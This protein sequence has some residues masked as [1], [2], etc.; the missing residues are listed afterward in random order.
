MGILDKIISSLFG[1]KK[2]NQ[3]VNNYSQPIN[4]TEHNRRVESYEEYMIYKKSSNYPDDFVIFDFE[5]T[6]L[7]AKEEKIIQIGALKYRNNERIDEFIT[8]VNPQRSIPSFITNL[9]GIRNNDVKNSPTIAQALPTFLEFIGSD[10]II[11]HNADFDMKFLLNN[12]FILNIKKIENKVIDTLSLSRKYIKDVNGNKLGNY[13]LQTLKDRL[14]IIVGSHN[15]EDDCMVCAE[16]YKKCK[17]IQVKVQV[18]S[19][20]KKENIVVDNKTSQIELQ[21]FE[22]VKQI[23]LKNNKVIKFLKPN[24]IGNYYD[25]L[26]FY[27]LVR[28]K[29]Q[30]KKQYILTRHSQDE[31]QSVWKEAICEA[32]TKGETG[33][34]RILFNS[35][36]D[37]FKIESLIIKDFDNLMKSLEYYRQ[38]VGSGESHIQE[39]L[40]SM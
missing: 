37:L 4:Q 40:S 36:D 28:I 5:T 18:H 27:S 16:V 33:T 6:G 30:G 35:P 8:Y 2:M 39:Y 20:P 23:L 21:C 9:T 7:S 38:G 13:K 11:A 26:S 15:S 12:A 14:G 19:K 25:I 3:S 17:E 1:N 29:L 24:H 31:I 22:N 34:T 32:A 10:V